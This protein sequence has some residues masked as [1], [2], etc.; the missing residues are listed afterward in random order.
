M[1]NILVVTIKPPEKSMK[2]M[3]EL[4]VQSMAHTIGYNESRRD[5]PTM[6]TAESDVAVAANNVTDG[7]VE[8]ASRCIPPKAVVP[9]ICSK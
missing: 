9:E 8:W 1:S 3:A 4:L 7:L 5:V 6:L 2:R